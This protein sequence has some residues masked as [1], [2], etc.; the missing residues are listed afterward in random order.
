MNTNPSISILAV[1]DAPFVL[2]SASLLL[3][4]DG[5]C[6]VACGNGKKAIEQWS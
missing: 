4:N 3:I 5:Y 2:D 6:V 1:D